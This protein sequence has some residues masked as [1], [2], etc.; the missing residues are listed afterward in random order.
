MKLNY[1]GLKK[2]PK[3]NTSISPQQQRQNYA[4]DQK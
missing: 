2:I 4:T 3:I 1:G